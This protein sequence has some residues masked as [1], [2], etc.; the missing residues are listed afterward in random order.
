[1]SVS[2]RPALPTLAVL[3]LLVAAVSPPSLSGGPAAHV[4][5]AANGAAG[6]SG[7]FGVSVGLTV[8]TLLGTAAA[9]T[10]PPT[11]TVAGTSS[12]PYRLTNTAAWVVASAPALGTGLTTGVLT[13]TAASEASPTS[14]T[15]TTTAS[16]TT[17]GLAFGLATLVPTSLTATAVRSTA[18]LTGPCGGPLAATGV[19]ALEGATLTVAGVAV[20]VPVNPAPNTVLANTAGVVIV[21]NEQVLTGDGTTSRGLT[22]NAL[23]ITLTGV[24]LPGIGTVS[25]EII[26]SQSRALLTCALGGA[27]GPGGGAA[28]PPPGPPGTANLG[29]ERTVTPNPAGTGQEVTITDTVT[30]GGPAPATGVVLTETLPEGVDFV[31]AT[32]SQGICTLNGRVV[33]C[34]LGTIPP[35][36]SATARIVV[37]TRSTGEFTLTGSVTSAVPDL[38]PSNN[39]RTTQLR[40]V[41]DAGAADAE[42]DDDD[43]ERPRLTEEEREQEQRTNRL[44]RDN[45]DIHGHVVGVRCQPSDPVP[46]AAQGPVPFNADDAPYAL[47]ITVDSPPA[48]QVRLLRDARQA[49]RSI[50]VGDYLEAEGEKQHEYL[51]D[52][53]DVELRRGGQ[54]VR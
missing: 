45:F 49:C 29:L 16:A 9:I 42:D 5:Y 32:P 1:M 28:V 20:T 34:T 18:T 17:N 37:R 13:V 51:F 39:Q 4:A 27:T 6:T 14:P 38:D 7:S 43:D 40:V 48:M 31:S 19:T 10:V 35:G 47:I 12:P 44:G 2:M 41:D 3:A 36:G 21:A 52:A 11:P 46:D 15:D 22:V 24:G 53:E 33:T 23:R 54:R 30:N 8:T 25:G 50:Q 26:V